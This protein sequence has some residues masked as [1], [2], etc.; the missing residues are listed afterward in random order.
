MEST[1]GAGMTTTD[2]HFEVFDGRGIAHVWTVERRPIAAD[3]MIE[4]VGTVV[5][6]HTVTEAREAWTAEQAAGARS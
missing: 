2:F 1:K 5:G 3:R 4:C 6:V